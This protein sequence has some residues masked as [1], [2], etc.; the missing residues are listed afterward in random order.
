[1]DPAVSDRVRNDLGV[2]PLNF[3]GC[4]EVGR[5]AAECPARDG[6][7]VNED[8][9]I[10]EIVPDPIAGDDQQ[11]YALLTALHSWAMPFLRYRIG[12]RVC[13]RPGRCSC[14]SVFRRIAAPA[15][16]DDDLLVLPGG[17][18]LSSFRCIFVLREHKPILRYRAIQEALDRLTIL[19]VA[20]EPM[21]PDSVNRIRSA[22]LEIIGEPMQ[23]DIQFV[24]DIPNEGPK[25]RSFISRLPKR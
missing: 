22:L 19:I 23:I 10:V 25:F 14:G 1:L 11:G 18:I 24:D 4:F 8:H 20:S 15:G 6:L 12:D 7:H 16:R 5:V 13:W 17:R 9:C 21:P 2:T 3:Y